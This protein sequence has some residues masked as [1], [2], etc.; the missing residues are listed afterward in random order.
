MLVGGFRI[1]WLWRLP[2]HP[3][4]AAPAS[5]P[6][7]KP[8]KEEDQGQGRC[9][10]A[11]KTHRYEPRRTRSQKGT[12]PSQHKGQEKPNDDDAG[13][14]MNCPSRARNLHISIAREPARKPSDPDH[15]CLDSQG[16][17]HAERQVLPQADRARHRSGHHRKSNRIG[18]EALPRC[19]HLGWLHGHRYELCLVTQEDS[20]TISGS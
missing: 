3:R 5:F 13:C 10:D 1:A 19:Q 11:R 2:V 12:G 17:Y 7:G 9:D 16:T 14:G 20:Q 8:D 15:Y 6:R 18:D 4:P